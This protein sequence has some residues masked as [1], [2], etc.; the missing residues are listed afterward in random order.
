MATH[1]INQARDLIGGTSAL[2]RVTGVKAPTVCQWISGDR[3]VP[4][5]FCPQIEMAPNGAVTRKDLR[6]ADWHLIWPE[7]RA[8]HQL[9]AEPA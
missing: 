6:P 9:Q 4:A 5:R 8:N 7:L 1:A 3:P 2:A